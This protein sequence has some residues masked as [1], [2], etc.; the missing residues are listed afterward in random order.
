V[1]RL[2]AGLPAKKHARHLEF[3]FKFESKVLLKNGSV[4]AKI[5]LA[6][7]TAFSVFLKLILVL[8]SC[9]EAALRFLW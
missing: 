4:P 8:D 6:S 5:Q 7:R 1:C 9:F 3:R 2:D